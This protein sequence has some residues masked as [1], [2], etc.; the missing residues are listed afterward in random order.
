MRILTT[1]SL[2][3]AVLTRGDQ[4]SDKIA[5]MLPGRLDTKDYINF[6]SHIDYLS[7]KGFYII[8]FDPPGTWDSPGN[9]EFTTTNYINA[10]NE[11]IE[12][13]GNKPTLLL[14]HSRGGQVA[15]IAGANNPSVIAFALV[16]AS[17]GLPTPPDPEQ[18]TNGFL[19][20]HRDLPPG[21]VKTTKQ[22]EFHLS[23]NY[24]KDGEQ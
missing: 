1:K 8:A 11:L 13:F 9:I 16:N 17:Y 4:N 21:D 20:E 23:L 14:R 22:K 24:F 15:M 3:L 5:I 18:V 12:Y 19:A 2:K 10:V 6:T 7:R